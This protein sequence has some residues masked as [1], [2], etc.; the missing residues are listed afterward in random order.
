MEYN[1]ERDGRR[2]GV[3]LRFYSSLLAVEDV[4]TGEQYL[5]KLRGRFKRQGIRPITGDIVEY[6]VVVGNEG[7]VEI[8]SIERTN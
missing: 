1:L 5:C 4:R 3:V 8:S 6:R 7:V 2:T